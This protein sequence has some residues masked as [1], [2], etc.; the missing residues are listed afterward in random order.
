MN[1]AGEKRLQER[2]DAQRHGSIMAGFEHRMRQGVPID[3]VEHGYQTTLLFDA[4]K[5]NYRALVDACLEA[6]ADPNLPTKRGALPLFEAIKGISYHNAKKLLE[7]GANVNALH[8][9]H[10]SPFEQWITDFCEWRIK[11]LMAAAKPKGMILKA[12]GNRQYPLFEHVLAD[13]YLTDPPNFHAFMQG[14]VSPRGLSRWKNRVEFMIH[15]DD[16]VKHYGADTSVWFNALMR[17]IEDKPGTSVSK[18]R[19]LPLLHQH[20]EQAVERNAL[21]R[22][23]RRPES[24]EASMGL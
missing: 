17:A 16:V 11:D 21:V 22:I 12:S 13:F 9:G 4:V 2:L 18:Q 3:E 10:T 6:G 19:F 15:C 8:C 24:T 5:A 23:T 20:L 14:D 7:H 1:R